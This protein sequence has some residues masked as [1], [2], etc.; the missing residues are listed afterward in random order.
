MKWVWL[1]IL[2]ICNIYI[3]HKLTIKIN[4]LKSWLILQWE[5]DFSGVS[6]ERE[7]DNITTKFDQS[8]MFTE[9][10]PFIFLNFVTWLLALKSTITPSWWLT[11]CLI[12]SSLFQFLLPLFLSTI[13]DTTDPPAHVFFSFLP[14]FS[15]SIPLAAPSFFCYC[16]F[17]TT[18]IY[19]A[20]I[21]WQIF[22]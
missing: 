1:S 14:S 7:L 9:T 18:P 11:R 19:E 10:P 16:V 22:S 5:F 8:T 13:F 3:I 4:K 15:S 2:Y 21:L 17:A 20:S 12:E 6:E